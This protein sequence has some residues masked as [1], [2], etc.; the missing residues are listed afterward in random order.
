M[1]GFPLEALNIDQLYDKLIFWQDEQLNPKGVRIKI[2]FLD[3]QAVEYVVGLEIERM[4]QKE[5][6]KMIEI[7]GQTRDQFQNKML[8]HQLIKMTIGE[9]EPSISDALSDFAGTIPGF[10]QTQY[11][12][13][14][15]QPP[16]LDLR[17]IDSEENKQPVF[18]QK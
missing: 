5:A 9:T 18:I 1:R 12:D 7:L 13:L 14:P 2:G 4:K 15:I 3:R 6:D 11:E 17:R 10:D 8:M 16:Q